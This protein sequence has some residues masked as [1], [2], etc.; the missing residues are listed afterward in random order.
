DAAAP[1]SLW[2][3]N[4]Q[5]LTPLT[6]PGYYIAYTDAAAGEA[7]VDYN[8]VPPSAPPGWPAVRS[9]ERGFSRFIYGFMIDRLRKVSR[10][11]TSGSGARK[12][13][14]IGSWFILCREP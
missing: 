12:G 10:H 11:V 8:R 4:F 2:G 3:F 13:R 5:S 14:E 7:L 9:N 6:G 1:R